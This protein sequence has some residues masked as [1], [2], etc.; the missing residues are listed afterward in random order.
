VNS[1]IPPPPQRKNH[2][3]HSARFGQGLVSQC[4]RDARCCGYRCGNCGWPN[5]PL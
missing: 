3:R 1:S 2:R 4:R 5:N